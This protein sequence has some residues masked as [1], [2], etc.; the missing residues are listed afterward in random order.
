MKQVVESEL[1]M[2]KNQAEHMPATH[3]R[4]SIRACIIA[5]NKTETTDD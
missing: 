2:W 3:V 5:T 1:I 4:T